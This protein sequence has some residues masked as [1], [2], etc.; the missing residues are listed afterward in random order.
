V[1]LKI[2]KLDQASTVEMLMKMGPDLYESLV[3]PA[4][5][6]QDAIDLARY[7]VETTMGFSKFS[8]ARPKTVGGPSKLPRSPNM[9]GSGG[10]REST[11]ILPP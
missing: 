5:P 9:K 10:W 6:I 2:G 3:M 8:I 4:M 7:L 11:F 1:L